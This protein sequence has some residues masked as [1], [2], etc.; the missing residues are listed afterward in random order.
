M[1]GK[2][3]KYELKATART[4]IPIYIGIL[5]LSLF[6]RVANTL[7][8]DELVNISGLVLGSLF[9][10]LAVVTLIVIIQ[11][12]QKNLLTDEGYLM[13]TLP[14]K[15]ASLIGAKLIVALIWVIASSLIAPIAGFILVV[16]MRLLAELEAYAVQQTL[17]KIFK[18]YGVFFTSGIY[19]ILQIYLAL[20]IPQMAR[21]S[22]HKTAVSFISF[23]GL[24]TII[25]WI[26]TK[27]GELTLFQNITSI[28]D[29]PFL[30]IM[31]WYI[32]ISVILFI[33]INNMLKKHLNLE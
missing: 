7:N 23:F 15:P 13:F 30:F 9:I 12:F 28:Q 33:A 24:H 21:I 6:N 2:L 16:D 29:M 10:A 19:I 4:F 14:V 25:T 11:R 26:T 5:F 1:L 17:G 3:L 18:V 31:A 32:G 8:I 27:V 20:S 22:K